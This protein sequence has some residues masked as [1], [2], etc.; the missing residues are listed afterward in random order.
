MQGLKSRHKYLKYFHPHYNTETRPTD[1]QSLLGGAVP[2]KAAWGGLA[3]P[4]AACPGMEYWGR[5]WAKFVPNAPGSWPPLYPGGNCWLGVMSPWCPL[6]EVTSLLRMLLS[7]IC[8]LWATGGIRAKLA[9]K[10]DT[11]DFMSD[12]SSSNWF[13]TCRSNMVSISHILSVIL[14]LCRTALAGLLPAK[15]SLE[16]CWWLSARHST[17]A[18]L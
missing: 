9:G 12:S 1:T 16:R 18:N 7:D 11:S 5:N 2:G 13:S 3:P 15:L 14:T 8:S 4:L 17:S 10:R 6:A